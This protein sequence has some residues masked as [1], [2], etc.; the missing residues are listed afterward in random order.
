MLIQIRN[1][2]LFVKS[3]IKIILIFIYLLRHDF[4]SSF[5]KVVQVIVDEEILND[6]E[7]VDRRDLNA[8]K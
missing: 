6:G 4:P 2:E 1:P 3:W 8:G 7:E 5:L